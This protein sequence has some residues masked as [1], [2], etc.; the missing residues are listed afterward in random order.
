MAI[1]PLAAL[2]G[3]DAPPK[4]VD[5]VIPTPYDFGLFSVARMDEVV[6]A[7]ENEGVFAQPYTCDPA[8]GYVR[9]CDEVDDPP[10]KSHE[11]NVRGANYASPYTLYG[12]Y[13][14]ASIGYSITEAQQIARQNLLLG[15]ERGAEAELWAGDLGSVSSLAHGINLDA[16]TITDLTPVAGATSVVTGVAA[17]ENWLGQ[18]Y[19]GVGMLHVQRGLAISLGSSRVIDFQAGSK[20]LTTI[21]GTRVSAG[22]GY[23][24]IGP[25]AIVDDAVVPGTDPADGEAWIYA[26]GDVVLRR[27]A[28]FD[29]PPGS[30][31]AAVLDRDLN[32]LTALSERIY[33]NWIDGCGIAAI[34]VIL[35]CCDMG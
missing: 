7:H 8:T 4:R 2:N 6:D 22:S 23:S 10:A 14:C 31:S 11:P 35:D 29:T 3:A 19:A 5:A 20:K 30:Q 18:N 17:L 24:G 25:D 27:S 1:N 16:S 21:L 12:Y 33:S 13:E 9:N 15:E 34:R 32:D 28:P 26:T